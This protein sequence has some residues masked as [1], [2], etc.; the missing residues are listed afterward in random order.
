MSNTKQLVELEDYE[1][2]VI[3]PNIYRNNSRYAIRL[4]TLD[5]EPFA[6]LTS[7]LDSVE[8]EDNEII[9]KMYSENEILNP[10]RNTKYFKDTE[11]RVLSGHSVLEIWE[12]TDSQL[13]K[14]LKNKVEERIN[15]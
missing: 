3:E 4:D 7:N 5:G 6:M 8:L 10:L 1:T 11:K 2:L 13:K 14:D 9:V 12:I 15:Q